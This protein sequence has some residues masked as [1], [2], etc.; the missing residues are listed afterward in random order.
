[1][2]QFLD[3]LRHKYL[4]KNFILL[5][6]ILILFLLL[7]GKAIGQ[8]INSTTYPLVSSTGVGLASYTSLGTL[9]SSGN[10]DTNSSLT[11]IGFD[12]WFN[13]VRYT[14]F[15]VNTNGHLKLGSVVTNINYINNLAKWTE[16]PKIAPYW[17]DLT[18]GSDGYVKYGLIGSAPN[19]RL[20]VEWKA[21]VYVN[22]AT[23]SN[24][25]PLLFQAILSETTGAIQF[26]Y[27]GTIATST[28]GYSIGFSTSSTNLVSV[29]SSSNVATYGSDPNTNQTA[30]IA[31]G[32]SHV[33][34]PQTPNAPS[35][36]TF[37]NVATTSMTLNWSDNA[38]NEQGYV[39][40]TSTD[41][42][43]YV[44][45][46][47]VAANDTNADLSGLTTNTTYYF[48][49][50]AITEG[51]LSS[52]PLT[53]S[54][55]TPVQVVITTGASTWVAPACVTSVTIE[56]WGAG[57]G[58]G[59]SNNTNTN[60]GSGGGGGAYAKG[61]H[62]VVPGSTYFYSVGIKGSGGPANSTTPPTAGGS[63][64]FNAV[65]STNV[66]PASNVNGTLAAG[67][68]P[69][70]NNSITTPSNAGL[71]SSSIGNVTV[72]SG[73]AGLGGTTAGGRNGGAGAS[74]GG[75]AGGAGSTTTNG[76]NGT[77]PG[78]GG[79]GGN[80]KKN[81]KGGDG[82]I[83][84]IIITYTNLSPSAVPVISSPICSGSTTLSGTSSEANGTIIELFKAGISLGTTTVTS[85]TWT[86]IGLLS[87][88]SGDVITAT[89]VAPSCKT[90][91]VSSVSVTVTGAPTPATNS[92]TQT[93][94]STSTATLSGNVPTVGT[95]A[96]SVV[97]GPSTLLS[98]FSSLTNPTA[99]FTPAGGVGS[100]V[101]RWTISNSPCT[102]STANAT[103]TVT[104]A[105]TPAMNSSTQTICSTATATLSAN[106][107]TVGTGAWSV[108]SGPSTLASQFSSLTNPTAV[109]TP[110]GGAGS[111]VVRWTISNLPCTA[112][113]ANA[114]ITVTGAPTIATNSSTQTICATATAILSGNTPT[115][116]TGAWSVVSGPS[117]L[118]SQFSSLT[119]PTAVFTPAGGVGSYVVR[120]T[121]SNAP[122]AAS[123]ANATITVGT[124]TVGGAVTGG[125]SI[126]SGS[127]SGLLTLS[128]HTGSV[129]RWESSVSPFSSWTPIATTSTTYTS[130]VLTQDTQFRAVVQSGSCS[131]VNSTPTTVSLGSTT[132]W[133][134][135]SWSNGVP[136]STSLAIISGNYNSSLNGGN[137][138]ACSLT[139]TNGIV[140][141]SSGN[142]VSLNGA[143]QVLS[144]SFTL[145]NNANLIQSSTVVNSGNIIVK[146]NTSPLIRQDYVL[147]SSPVAAQQLLAFSPATLT[148]R[149]YTYD[150]ATD[151]YL[152]VSSPATTNFALGTGYLIRV[153]NTHPT[154]PTIW[155]GQFTGVPNNGTV[156]LTV[157]N[158]TYN[159][160]GNP[161]PSTIDA[162][163]FIAANGITEALYFWRK[164]NNSNNSSYATYTTAGG[165]SN[166]GGDTLGLTPSGTIAVG[167]GFIVKSTS[168]T[169]SFTNA[170]RVANSNAPFL[171][172]AENRNRIWLNLSS[173]SGAFYQTMVSYM[174]NATSA[175]DA[176]ID[177]RFLK[178]TQ[179][180]LISLI[181]N[182]EFAIQG[183]ALPFDPSDVV[184][185]GFKAKVADSYTI[186]LSNFDGLFTNG[187]AI[188]LKDKLTNTIHDLKSGPYV[189][190][191]EAGTFN[192]R[193]EIVYQNALA[194]HQTNFT[195][196][197]VVV[198]K[199]NQE[200]VINTGTIRM[201]NVQIYDVTGRLLMTKNNINDSQIK[202]YTGTTK[203]VLLVKITSE[204][205]GSVLKKIIN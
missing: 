160:I 196:N 95:G 33:F 136:T 56:T 198:Y 103:I 105:P 129:I 43:N 138:T 172:V 147:W 48:K 192:A 9:V 145:E 187:Q 143:L 163:T 76:S 119:N 92:S 180:A 199:Q 98:Q 186:T 117:T 37:A 197:S 194:T 14:Q 53:G 83:G 174:P 124:G 85:G 16:N 191:S 90:V 69:G 20:V 32:K 100:Y 131:I 73:S 86:K 205:E 7:T 3:Y 183:R 54:Q 122:C 36:L 108:V 35:N 26:I 114:T 181:D 71:A 150:S 55:T 40:Y 130:G 82:A 113:T 38:S 80:D 116:G 202:I 203:E 75:G 184:L 200:L 17:D 134:G 142:N 47:Q 89:A 159:A 11:N 81:N 63:T 13:G 155:G 126:C 189:F 41:G 104:G 164:T 151:K 182:E 64:W 34:T 162:D 166:S 109:F 88:V 50:Y 77:T 97:S 118:A 125:S 170:M 106:A 112:S 51:T 4:E 39:I 12:F 101:V 22:N 110:A 5:L 111:Y 115:V 93:I 188:Y 24:S 68:G 66:A 28:T 177:G 29:A 96:W 60:G 52:P 21:N 42:V 6:Y 137:I 87:L 128:G 161:Y 132:T 94:C 79:G 195:E 176:T 107:P 127:T 179:T 65:A 25:A 123:T 67:G 70:V 61:I 178:D 91:S 1:M 152:T 154:T 165:V 144:G 31:A 120:W 171:R 58:G 18:T 139:V 59:S 135:S 158:A 2:K 153:P 72:A 175:I 204:T 193:F 19:R 62:T 49:V 84:Q 168:T 133:N 78:G 99:V 121:I 27:G 57:G 45:N 185:L 148:N 10:D 140:I 30:S 201:S 169:I 190:A 156:N 8:T 141:I 44:F 157:A 167:Q 15:G 173:T 46:Q 23:V 102:A 149:F 146:R 74:P